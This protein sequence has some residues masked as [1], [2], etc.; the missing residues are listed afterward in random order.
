MITTQTP[1]SP[2]RQGYSRPLVISTLN[3]INTSV[4]VIHRGDYVSIYVLTYREYVRMYI[5]VHVR[6]YV[7]VFHMSTAI[8]KTDQQNYKNPIKRGKCQREVRTCVDEPC[9]HLTLLLS[10]RLSW[11]ILLTNSFSPP[12]VTASPVVALL[13]VS[14]AG[15]RPLRDATP[16]NRSSVS[17]KKG[18][19]HIQNAYWDTVESTTSLSTTSGDTSI[20]GGGRKEQQDIINSY[21]LHRLCI[22]R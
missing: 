20:T 19:L 21:T 14:A 3:T 15:R 16:P 5:H 12:L 9:T 6:I 18:G 4:C 13:N 7:Q 22:H 17:L 10:C 2:H 1:F 11:M 8:K